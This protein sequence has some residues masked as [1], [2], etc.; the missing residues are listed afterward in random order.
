M[1]H[2]QQPD[3]Y[4]DTPSNIADR[5]LTKAELRAIIAQ[6]VYCG[7]FS[8]IAREAHDRSQTGSGTYIK[9]A[10]GSSYRIEV[11]MEQGTCQG[12]MAS[13][14]PQESP[15]QVTARAAVPPH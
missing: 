1:G 14:F 2:D 12:L 7:G 11:I 3:Y 9:H 15:L 5:S 4:I 13:L 8:I 6:A 10:A